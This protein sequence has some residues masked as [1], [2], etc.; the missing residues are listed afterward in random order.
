VAA[1]PASSF[2]GRAGLLEAIARRFE[3]GARLV[4]LIGPPGIGKTRLALR[5]AETRTRDAGAR[6]CF[7]D[8]T[9]ARDAAEVR[10]AVRTSL[11]IRT[12]DAAPVSSHG[13]TFAE[14]LA[15]RGPFLLVLD[16][17]EQLVP[18]A[19]ELALWLTHAPALRLLVTSR[20]RLG[21]PGEDIVE[22]GPLD[23]PAPDAAASDI[24][25]SEAVR[26]L[27]DRARSAGATDVE[28]WDPG[29][30]GA[31]ARALDGIPLAI[32]LAAA[33]ARTLAPGEILARLTQRFELL[34]ARGGDELDRHATLERAIEWSWSLLSSWEQQALAQCSVFEGGF[35]LAAA[36]AI[37]VLD[38]PGSPPVVEVLG[39]L[40]D[41]SLVVARPAGASRRFHLYVSI[42]DY[43]AARLDPQARP[44]V[45][46][47]HAAH[48]VESSEALAARVTRRADAGALDAL[49]A[50]QENV[51][52]VYR[53]ALAGD[54]SV[55]VAERAVRVVLALYSALESHGPLDQLLSMLDTSVRLAKMPGIPARLLARASSC[56]GNAYGFRG[57]LQESISDLEGAAAMAQAAG[58]DETL[59]ET[60]VWLSVRYRHAGRYGDALAACDRAYPLLEGAGCTRMT[61]LCLAVR[62]R[63]RGEIGQRREARADNQRAMAV[64]REL[65]D[66]RYEGLTLANLGQLAME[67][68]ELEEA[69]W[70]YEQSL[71]AFRE[72]GDARFE[73]RYVGYLG[74]LDWETG[75]LSEARARLTEAIAIV[76]RTR[77][78]NYAPLFRAVLGGLLAQLGETDLARV[79]LDRAETALVDGGVPAYVA[80]TRAHRGQL[81]L[82]LARAAL[83]LPEGRGEATRLREA[84]QARLSE[85]RS[86]SGGGGG[87]TPAR[88]IDGSDDVRFAAR[89]LERA[90]AAMDDGPS[91]RS[92]LVV[93]PE[94]R[95]FTAGGA[96][97][98]LIRRGPVRL[99]LL[100]LVRH[101]L[102]QPGKALRQEALLSAGWPGERVLPDSGSKRVRVA[103]ATL[104][105]LGLEGALVTRDDGYLL[106]PAIDV[107]E[108]G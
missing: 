103:I 76:E 88:L 35:T 36:E 63:M 73:G 84:A 56:R 70:Y 96:R 85:V 32:E 15:D 30:V 74:C 89:M 90:L 51:T 20:E 65:G 101:R 38:S 47:R 71:V 48:Y 17:F 82:A 58:D 23:L 83:G 66:R 21:I 102:Q 59:G 13:Q 5:F 1:S 86:I 57:R 64:F 106:D 8:L 3:D 53:R 40:C 68:G 94:A 4:T 69:R 44:H 29:P 39:A 93:G 108:S 67:D 34:R 50:D 78:F 16:N 60:L 79:Q 22:L 42:A 77:T 24:L 61:G 7:C 100:A 91:A 43:A 19:G 33:R 41:K 18:C 72:V 12:S 52:A 99:L 104:R 49:L 31:L 9:A 80:A 107:R 14:S 10:A 28:A 87:E 26:L 54:P 45:E 6:P 46:E 25:A 11:G 92:P 2:V 97:V 105:R 75:R 81:D 62:G 95:W 55:R 27:A 98:D 37:L